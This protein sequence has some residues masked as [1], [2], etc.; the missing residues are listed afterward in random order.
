MHKPKTSLIV[1]FVNGDEEHKFHSQLNSIHEDSV[2]IVT[3]LDLNL[4]IVLVDDW[5]V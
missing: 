3:Y 1:L 2:A 5:A 4:N